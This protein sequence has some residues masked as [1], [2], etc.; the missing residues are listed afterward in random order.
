VVKDQE[1]RKE[2]K[3]PQVLLDLLEHKDHL[4]QKE[5]VVQQ[6]LPEHRVLLEQ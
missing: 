3:E 4:V 5:M 6:D 2:L 1:V